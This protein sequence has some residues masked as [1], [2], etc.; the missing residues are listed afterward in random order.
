MKAV[1]LMLMVLVVCLVMA[2][3]SSKDNNPLNLPSWY[4]SPPQDSNYM[5]AAT[6]SSS[7]DLQ[8][9]INKSLMDGRAAI[10]QQMEV[11]MSGM[12]RRFQEEVGLGEDSELLD[13][14]TSAYKSVVEETL[15]GSRAREQE[16]RQENGVYRAYTLVEMPI[17]AASEA[18]AQRI[19]ENNNMY[20]RFRSTE[21]FRDL[22]KEIE[23]YREWRERQNR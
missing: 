14:F 19:R 2:C 6:T 1:N 17:G 23:D 21:A 16:I 5:F 8:V 18:L 15:V 9:A 13:Q 12:Q 4:L 10:A 22:E 7:R 3:G 20:T 11:R